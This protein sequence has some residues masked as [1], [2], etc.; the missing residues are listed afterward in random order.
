MKRICLLFVIAL[1]FSGCARFQHSEAIQ[2]TPRGA[3]G[4]FSSSSNSTSSPIW[5]AKRQ[6]NS[7]GNPLTFAYSVALINNSSRK[8]TGTECGP[9][10]ETAPKTTPSL[11]PNFGRQPVLD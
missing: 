10:T 6:W 7:Q 5:F 2:A 8:S 1:V 9:A 3:T 11:P 4:S